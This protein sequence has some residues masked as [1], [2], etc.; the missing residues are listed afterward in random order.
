[1]LS[2]INQ[3]KV[4][5]SAQ[6][7]SSDEWTRRVKLTIVTST[8]VGQLKNPAWLLLALCFFYRRPQLQTEHSPVLIQLSLLGLMEPTVR[9][10]CSGDPHTAALWLTAA[11]S[12]RLEHTALVLELRR[13]FSINIC[14]MVHFQGYTSD[15]WWS[16][17]H[18]V[19]QKGLI[20]V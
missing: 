16:L 14:S 6:S 11:I 15:V 10:K 12:L 19:H 8:C 13:I 20:L 3:I 18:F 17:H 5:L 1:M 4:S 9:Y 7:V 2:V